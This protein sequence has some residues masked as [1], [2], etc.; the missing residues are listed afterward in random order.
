MG[1]QEREKICC[2]IAAARLRSSLQYTESSRFMIRTLTPVVQ[3]SR[4]ENSRKEKEKAKDLR[5]LLTTWTRQSQQE[6][7][8]K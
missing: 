1:K 6:I 8:S 2:E 7:A 4:K 3:F 5:L